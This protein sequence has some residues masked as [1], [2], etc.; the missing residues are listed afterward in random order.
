MDNRKELAT[1]CRDVCRSRLRGFVIRRNCATFM[2]GNYGKPFP[3]EAEDRSCYAKKKRNSA[4]WNVFSSA[5]NASN[6]TRLTTVVLAS[7]F[8]NQKEISHEGQDIT[9]RLALEM[10]TSSEKARTPVTRTAI[11][12]RGGTD[13]TAKYPARW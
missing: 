3:N 5:F 10:S 12:H 9:I 1:S 6:L 2:G 11:L 7:I 8:L 4:K 13:L